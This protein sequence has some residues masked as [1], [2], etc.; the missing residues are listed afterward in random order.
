MYRTLRLCA[1]AAALFIAVPLSPALA[2]SKDT[3]AVLHG[4]EPALGDGQGRVYFYRDGGFMGA[5]VQPLIYVDG[6][7][8]GRSKPGDYFFVDLPAGDH[9]IS[10]DTEKE[11]A[12][13]VTVV[14]GQTMFVKT[15]VTMGLF[16]GHVIPSVVANATAEDEIKDCDF[17]PLTPPPA[18]APA[19]ATAS[20]PAETPAAP[21]SPGTTPAP[22]TTTDPAPA[23]G[24]PH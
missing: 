5:A 15:E 7:A 3:Y 2:A 4:T 22:A 19:P 10:T 1:L 6:T 11:E 18:P 16:V 20:T 13:N 21:P 17:H 9:K 23:A 8:G 12:I 14:T 24:T